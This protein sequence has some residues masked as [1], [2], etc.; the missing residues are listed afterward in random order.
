MDT[1]G[2]FISCVGFGGNSIDHFSSFKKDAIG[3]IYLTGVFYDSADLAPFSPISDHYSNG[4]QDIF[5]QK[6]HAP[7]AIANVIKTNSVSVFPNPTNRTASIVSNI[8][9]REVLVS[10]VLGRT[11]QHHTLQNSQQ[12]KLNLELPGI[13]FITVFSGNEVTTEKLVVN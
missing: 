8:P 9:I 11:V 4:G 13:Y 6:L 1:A 5:L 7:T 3:N 10:D 2:N 12:L